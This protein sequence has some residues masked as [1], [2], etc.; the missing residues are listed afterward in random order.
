MSKRL[1]RSDIFNNFKEVLNTNPEFTN[2]IS[3]YSQTCNIFTPLG[4]YVMNKY[5]EYVNTILA[6]IHKIN[7][8]DLEYLLIMCMMTRESARWYASLI[9]FRL[10]EK[11]L[12]TKSFLEKEILNENLE[13]FLK[14]LINDYLENQLTPKSGLKSIQLINIHLKNVSDEEWLK[15]FE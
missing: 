8:Q 1:S 3:Y 11:N 15:Y 14:I 9:I 10:L 5:T 12:Y 13:D 4:I 7:D 6:N 2:I